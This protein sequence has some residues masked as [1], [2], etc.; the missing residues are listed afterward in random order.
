MQI[1]CEAWRIVQAFIQADAQVPKEVSLPRPVDREVARI[2][3]ER[4]DFAVIDVIDAIGVFGQPQLLATDD[5]QV[6]LQ[7]LKGQ[8]AVDTLVA[9]ISRSIE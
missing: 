2:L 5:K 9:P 6:A 4:R 3:A 8:A 7:N 1:F